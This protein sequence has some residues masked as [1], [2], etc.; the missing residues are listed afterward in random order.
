MP[1]SRRQRIALG[2]TRGLVYSIAFILLVVGLVFAAL[3]TGWGKNQLRAL[4]VRQ[5]NQYLTAT[6]EIDRL[7]GSL[8][9]GLRLTGVRLSQDGRVLVSIEDVSVDYSLRELF[10]R[11][12]V[13]RGIRIVRPHVSAGRLP[14]GRWDLSAL[15]KREARD[16][17]RTGPSRPITLQSVEVVDGTVV[18]RDPLKYGPAFVPTRYDALNVSLTY[19]Y[20]PVAWTLSFAHASWKG[21][22]P[23]LTVTRLAGSIASGSGGLSFTDLKVE[24]PRTT[25]TLDGRIIRDVKPTVVDLRVIADRFAFQEWTGVIRELRNVVVEAA[26]DVSLK[27]PLAKLATGITLHSNGGGVH[28][29]L[30]LDTTAPGWRGTGAVELTHLDV[31]RWFNLPDRPSDVSGHVDFNLTRFAPRFPRGSYVFK[32]GHTAF[33]GYKADSLNAHG[34]ITD[35]E[36]RIAAASGIAY[37]SDITVKD[38]EIAIDRPFVFHFAGTAGQVDLRALPESFPVPHVE[39]RL[40]FDYDVTGQFASS[41]VDAHAVF[42]ASEF[43]GATVGAGTDRIGEYLGEAVSIQR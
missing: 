33:L 26:F 22:A 39:S 11:G 19:A 41:F 43:L 38:G 25:F 13:V 1:R 17:Q 36:V 20:E 32:G 42:A 31:S 6:L 34:T 30:V 40:A 3:E 23:N 12:V 21:D 35:R 14:D 27:G 16:R 24:T 28:G 5:A 18:L 4:I 10:D 9:R 37:G 15:V 29:A 2:L 7:Q 8:V